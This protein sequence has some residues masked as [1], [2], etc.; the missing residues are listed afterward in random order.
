M[1]KLALA[2]VRPIESRS[3]QDIEIK[4]AKGGIRKSVLSMVPNFIAL[5]PWRLNKKTRVKTIASKRTIVSAPRYFGIE[6]FP[7][8]LSLRSGPTR[9][10]ARPPRQTWQALKRYI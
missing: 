10:Y 5:I 8:A 9:P 7:V 6:V 3:E 1:E 2:D 4:K